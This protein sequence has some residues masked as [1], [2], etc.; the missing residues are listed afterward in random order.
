MH[1]H[2]HLHLHLRLLLRLN[3]HLFRK[4]ETRVQSPLPTTRKVSASS[5]EIQLALDICHICYNGLLPGKGRNG[6]VGKVTRSTRGKGRR[7]LAK[8]KP[9][10]A[11]AETMRPTVTTSTRI[12]FQVDRQISAAFIR[13]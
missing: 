13:K 1:L 10:K 6:G 5:G 8:K 7:N 4:K 9:V 11:A 2:L 12:Y 3:L